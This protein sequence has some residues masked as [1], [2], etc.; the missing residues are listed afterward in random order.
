MPTLLPAPLAAAVVTSGNSVQ[1]EEE[2]LWVDLMRRIPGREGWTGPSL[3]DEFWALT[4][5]E[6]AEVKSNR[7]RL[8][9]LVQALHPK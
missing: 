3:D 4:D 7:D 5:Q 2:E 9:R 1:E 8:H 6:V